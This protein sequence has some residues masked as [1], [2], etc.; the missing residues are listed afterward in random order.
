VV[1]VV[2]S[3]IALGV[4]VLIGQVVVLSF[5]IVNITTVLG[6]SGWT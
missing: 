5:F 1:G 6:L 4:A 2:A 3:L